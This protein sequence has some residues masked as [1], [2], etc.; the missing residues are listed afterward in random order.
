[1]TVL[2]APAVTSLKT[3]PSPTDITKGRCAAVCA[4]RLHPQGRRMSAP[5]SRFDT[6]TVSDPGSWSASAPERSLAVLATI[7]RAPQKRP[8]QPDWRPSVGERVAA[9]TRPPEPVT[10]GGAKASEVALQG[11]PQGTDLSHLSHKPTTNQAAPAA[12]VA[13]PSTVRPEPVAPR[14]PLAAQ[15]APSQPTGWAEAVRNI[16]AVLAPYSQLIVLLGLLIAAGLSL[17][18]LYGAPTLRSDSATAN[19]VSTP[20]IEIAGATA[21][22]EAPLHAPA[23]QTPPDLG[24]IASAT[25]PTGFPAGALTAGRERTAINDDPLPYPKTQA[26]D[27]PVARLS[28][29]VRTQEAPSDELH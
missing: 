27:G 10:R 6:L 22:T 28:N 1:M 12:P 26:G 7:P 4:H 5:Y 29:M 21:E 13:T 18:I 14:R 19:S 23:E 11:P 8:E 20:R 25:G 17:M 9:P 3:V 15:P 2:P 16:E 24:E